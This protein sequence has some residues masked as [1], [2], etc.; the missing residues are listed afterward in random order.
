MAGHPGNN[1]IVGKHGNNLLGNPHAVVQQYDGHFGIQL[2]NQR[3]QCGH[4]LTGF[5]HHQQTLDLARFAGETTLDIEQ[6]NVPFQRGEIKPRMQGGLMM[7]AQQHS[8]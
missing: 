7:L 4:H 5:G 3:R 2:A 8:G 1:R 6:L